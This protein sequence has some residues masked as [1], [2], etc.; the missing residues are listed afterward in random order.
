[1]VHATGNQNPSVIEH[2]R[3]MVTPRRPQV[4]RLALCPGCGIVNLGGNVRDRLS[5][6]AALHENTSVFE[7]DRRVVSPGDR[8]RRY[9][10]EIGMSAGRAILEKICAYQRERGNACGNNGDEDH[11]DDGV[12]EFQDG[13]SEIRG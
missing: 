2:E 10:N 1:M 3:V 12:R 8:E 4:R 11:A 7:Q 9:R 13:R 6:A 5:V